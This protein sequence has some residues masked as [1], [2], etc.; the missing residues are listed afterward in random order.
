MRECRPYPEHPEYKFLFFPKI[1]RSR[2]VEQAPSALDWLKNF[3]N[4]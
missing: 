2:M 4:L 1:S 3:S